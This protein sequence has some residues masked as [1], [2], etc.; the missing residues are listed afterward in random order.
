MALKIACI[1]QERSSGDP[2]GI[3]SLDVSNLQNG[4]A[5]LG[6]LEDP[7]CFGRC[8]CQGLFDEHMDAM[9]KEELCGLAMSVRWRGDYGR[10]NE[11]DQVLEV[12][13]GSEIAE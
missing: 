7:K 10:V 12:F 13:A 6:G 9:V 1:V 11:S 4:L 2:G 3:E 5:A 8:G